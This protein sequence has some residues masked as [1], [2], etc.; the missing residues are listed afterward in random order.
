MA[1]HHNI[2]VSQSRNNLIKA[3]NLSY[4]VLCLIRKHFYIGNERRMSAITATVQQSITDPDQ[5][6]KRRKRIKIKFL[7]I[8]LN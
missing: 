5:C 2:K 4:N 8:L 7:V 1:Q 3:K 6:D